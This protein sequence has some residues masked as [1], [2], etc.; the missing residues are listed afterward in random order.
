[1]G[2]IWIVHLTSD[3]GTDLDGRLEVSDER[4]RFTPG[5]HGAAVP[6]LVIERSEIT[7]V[8]ADARGMRH[9]VVVGLRDRRRFEF[10]HGVRPVDEL[11]ALL[12]GP[13]TPADPGTPPT[14]SPQTERTTS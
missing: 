13:A 3:D 12:A 9:R 14:A 5:T 7:S 11:V 10:D 8:D 4:V 1:M 2:T 6:S